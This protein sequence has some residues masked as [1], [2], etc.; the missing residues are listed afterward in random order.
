[1]KKILMM[2]LAAVSVGARGA[3]NTWVEA[4]VPDAVGTRITHFEPRETSRNGNDSFLGSIDEFDPEQDYAP[5]KIFA[6]WNFGKYVFVEATW[7]HIEDEALSDHGSGDSDG[8]IWMSGPV[9][10]LNARLLN[11]SRFTPYAGVGLAIW[12]AGFDH[13]DWHHYGFDSIADWKAVGEPQ[14]PRNGKSRDIDLENAV[15]F[16]AAVG[17]DI[18]L[19]AHWHLDLLCRY[20]DIETD[21]QFTVQFGEKVE[22]R[23]KGTFPMEHFAAGAGIAYVF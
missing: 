13:A 20:V 1:M 10:T 14:Q 7:D 11:E 19:T 22:N 16:V 8:D 21:Y 2:V 12:D 9:L 18:E 15:G 6:Q 17:L 23:V 3:E 5:V 4:L